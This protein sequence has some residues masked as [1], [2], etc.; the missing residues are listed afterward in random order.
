M[1]SKNDIKIGDL[2][3]RLKVISLPYKKGKNWYAKCECTCGNIAEIQIGNLFR[4][5]TRSCGCLLTERKKFNTYDLTGDYGVG[6]TNNIDFTDPECKRNYYY[7][8]LEDYNKIKDYYWLFDK[9]GY[10]YT[11][12][13]PGRKNLTMHRLIMDCP[14]ELEVDHIKHHNFDNRKKE[15]RICTHLQNM[16]NKNIKNKSSEVQGVYYDK[17]NKR[18]VAFLTIQKEYKLLK[19][20]KTFEEAVAARK[21][22]EDKY[23]GEFSY[24]NSMKLKTS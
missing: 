24:D 9:N 11:R 14:I 1:P 20:F 17:I 15:L 8:D 12:N 7:F 2:Y 5:H 23:F 22:A 18:W 10:L 13:T 21:E 3:G 4:G 19:S 16:Q 6:Y